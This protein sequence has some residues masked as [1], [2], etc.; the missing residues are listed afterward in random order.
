MTPTQLAA[1]L[2]LSVLANS[3][4]AVD[5]QE[6]RPGDLAPV[7]AWLAEHPWKV[8]RTGPEVLVAANCKAWPFDPAVVIVAAAYGRGTIGADGEVD[9]LHLGDKNFVVALVSSM[10][11]SCATCSRAAS[12]TTSGGP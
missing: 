4:W 10:T 12:A 11:A 9:D 1:T 7:D 3:A 5:D 6:C 2:A 8:G